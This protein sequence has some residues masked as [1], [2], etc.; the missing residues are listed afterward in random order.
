MKIRREVIERVEAIA[1]VVHGPQP[2]APA[3]PEP[4]PPKPEP[5]PRGGSGE[6]KGRADASPTCP[7]HHYAYEKQGGPTSKAV[8]QKCG[9]QTEGANSVESLKERGGDKATRSGLNPAGPGKC[10]RCREGFASLHHRN[11]CPDGPTQRKLL[12]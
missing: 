5:K 2:G 1:A 11:E 12:L 4:E 6:S 9:D 8:C 7:P 3:L 10:P